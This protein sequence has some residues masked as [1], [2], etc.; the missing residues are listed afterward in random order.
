MKSHIIFVDSDVVISSLIS[1]KGAAH[2]LL[3]TQKS[4]FVI[5]NISKKELEEVVDRLELSRDKLEQ[6]VNERFEII[7]LP[8]TLEKIKR[9]FYSYTSDTDDTHIVAGAKKAKAKFLL[10]YNLRHFNRRKIQ[11][12]LGITILTPAQYLQYLRSL[13]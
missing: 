11:E 9:D 4:N 2:L 8:T 1:T 7:P 10:T 12:D 5:S 3:Y 13:Q 6:L